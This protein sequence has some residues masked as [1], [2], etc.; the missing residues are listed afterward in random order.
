MDYKHKSEN[1]NWLSD[2]SDADIKRYQKLYEQAQKEP[3][4]DI[5]DIRFG[6]RRMLN[7]P[8]PDK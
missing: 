8:E 1:R 6:I 3:P 4:R 2:L 5:K 7:P